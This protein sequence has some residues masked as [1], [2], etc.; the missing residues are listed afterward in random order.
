MPFYDVQLLN[1]AGVYY[2]VI[3]VFRKKQFTQTFIFFFLF[4]KWKV[5]HIE[6]CLYK[7]KTLLS[8]KL[9]FKFIPGI[10]A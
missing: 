5:V 7:C 6:T 3:V 8:T 10:A 2:F 9:K 4:V 1:H